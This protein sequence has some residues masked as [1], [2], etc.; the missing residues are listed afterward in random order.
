YP[1]SYMRA[2]GIKWLASM[3][4]P[5]RFKTTMEREVEQF[6]HLFFNVRLSRS[7]I[8][9]LLTTGQGKRSRQ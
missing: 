7:Q 3:V 4:Y 5:E 2:I 8:T 9:S 6:F 1:P